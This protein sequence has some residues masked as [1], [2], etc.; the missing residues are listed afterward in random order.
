MSKKILSISSWV[1]HGAYVALCL[2][3]ILL[4][5]LYRAYSPTDF[6]SDY[7]WLALDMMG[8]ATL[9]P[10]MPIG[11]ILNA[12]LL[13]LHITDKKEK[14]TSKIVWQSVRTALCPV[15]CVVLWLITVFIF[16]HAT[17]GV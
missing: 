16:V 15:L 4:C 13:V 1:A 10:F 9:I 17:G 3:V 12:I 11:F 14:K 8:W 2:T 5:M 6:S 7:A